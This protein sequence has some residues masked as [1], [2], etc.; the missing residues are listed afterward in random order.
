MIYEQEEY[1]NEVTKSRINIEGETKRNKNLAVLY[2]FDHNW[3]R[4]L[5]S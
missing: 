5:N 2:C 4:D 3:L 1:M